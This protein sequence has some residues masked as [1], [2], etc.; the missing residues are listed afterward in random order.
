[1]GTAGWRSRGST[2]LGAP[3]QPR[4]CDAR[5]GN[6]QDPQRSVASLLLTT[7]ALLVEKREKKKAAPT[8]GGYNPDDVDM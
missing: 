6:A 3:Q 8:P 4:V 2:F 1:M 7:E 5:R